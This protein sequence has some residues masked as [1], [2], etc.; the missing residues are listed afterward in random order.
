M[1]CLLALHVHSITKLTQS[2]FRW[3]ACQMDYLCEL[4]NDQ[5]RREA[6][7]KLPPGLQGTYERILERV[8]ASNK[9]NQDLV[10]QVLHWMIGAQSSMSMRLL[11]E[12]VAIK[13]G[14]KRLNRSALSREDDILR[15][16]SSLIRRG[17]PESDRV[18]LAHFTVK[19]FLLGIDPDAQHSISQYAFNQ[20]NVDRML[21][22]TCLTVLNF[23]EFD[24]M[25]PEVPES[26]EAYIDG[27]RNDK[28][29]YSYA[30]QFWPHHACHHFDD[31]YILRTACELFIPSKSNQFLWWKQFYLVETY[32]RNKISIPDFPDSTT[33]HWAACLGLDKLCKWLLENGCDVNKASK[34]GTPLTC[35]LAS[36]S[37]LYRRRRYNDD[38]LKPG[39][40]WRSNTRIKTIKVLLE[41]N[42][43][44]NGIQAPNGK[45]SPLGLALRTMHEPDEVTV[46]H[47][48]LTHGARITKSEIAYVH[49]HMVDIEVEG[50]LPIR[51]LALLDEAWEGNVDK[52]ADEII[53]LLRTLVQTTASE[54]MAAESRAENNK[55][56]SADARRAVVRNL[57]SATRYGQLDK[58]EK[59]RERLRRGADD[60]IYNETVNLALH[61]AIRNQH[62]GIVRFL[63]E[64]GVSAQDHLDSFGNTPLHIACSCTAEDH[65]EQVKI[66]KLL[67]G[68][69]AEPSKVNNDGYLPLHFAAEQQSP[70]CVQLFE[71]SL[72]ILDGYQQKAADGKTPVWCAIENGNDDTVE[73]IIKRC[74]TDLL[75]SLSCGNQSCLAPAIR[76]D[77]TKVLE[78]LL[79]RNLD[80]NTK[81]GDGA[82]AFHHAADDRGSLSSFQL[83]LE[84]GIDHSVYNQDGLAPIH[85]LCKQPTQQ[86]LEKMEILLDAGANPN[87]LSASRFSSLQFLVDVK[88]SP[89]LD[90]IVFR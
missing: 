30:T 26:L 65:G 29:L 7:Q 67:I 49:E 53:S 47:S 70:E 69:K 39:L 18:E 42:A 55:P 44:V 84:S 12:G 68:H 80:A 73:Y 77:T 57:L 16:C 4:N 46:V 36:K 20:N 82:T 72:G 50:L 3:V 88:H 35:A 85:L 71:G 56:L 60:K 24:T 27:F 5:A 75:Q 40:D 23:D 52:D 37:A 11:L 1:E 66:T 28:P 33:L 61:L 54:K 8:N 38:H 43:K 31:E 15:W 22:R 74:S 21:A 48:L 17:S 51:G 78:L 76:R 14:D 81:M 58:V 59:F 10:K 64:T 9:G 32:W 62:S 87:L 86:N 6:L 25:P 34:M 90:I 41:A 63:L 2:R 45:L 13:D 89:C 79:D 19:E 83:L